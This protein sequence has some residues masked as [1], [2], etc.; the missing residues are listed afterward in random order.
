PA[1]GRTDTIRCQEPAQRTRQG[2]IGTAVGLARR[3]RC[4]RGRPR[5]D[6]EVGRVIGDV[7]VAEHTRWAQSCTDRVRTACNALTRYAAV[8][9]RYT[10]TGE[11]TIECPGQG[12]IG[13]TIDLARRVRCHRSRPRVDRKGH[14]VVSDVVVAEYTRWTECRTDLVRA[15]RN[16]LTRSAAVGRTHAIRCQETTER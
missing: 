13:V 3:I 16:G 2:R 15:T 8:T 4:H 6:R 11:E 9:C 1:L 7:V 12:R 5:V 14:R 10:I